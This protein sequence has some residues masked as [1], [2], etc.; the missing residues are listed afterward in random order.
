[1][2]APSDKRGTG[3]RA[4]CRGVELV[5]AESAVGKALKVRRLNRSAERAA[6]SE[7]NIVRQDQDNVRSA[8][9][10]FHSF[11]EIRSRVL[12]GAPNRSFERRQG[13]GQHFLPKRGRCEQ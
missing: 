7:A 3:W 11:C 8:L 12:R 2:I 10:R 6:R 1:M 9:G 4:K 13:L 5:V